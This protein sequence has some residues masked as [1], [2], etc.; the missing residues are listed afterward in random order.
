MT[1]KAVTHAPAHYID[2]GIAPGRRGHRPAG[3]VGT[4]YTGWLNFQ[5]LYEKILRLGPDLL[6]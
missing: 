5:P 2:F 3:Q 1:A 6:A 4:E